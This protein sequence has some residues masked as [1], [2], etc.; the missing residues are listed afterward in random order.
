MSSGY[1]SDIDAIQS[2]AVVPTILDVVCRTTGMRFAAVARVTADRWIACTVKDDIAFGLKPGGELKIDTTICNDIRGSHEPVI[3]NHVAKDERYRSHQTPA[4]Y[5]FQSYISMPILLPDGQ[6]FGTLCAIDPKPAQLTNPATIGMF[7]L[8]AELIGYHLD[9]L[10]RADAIVTDL[11]KA[12]D[13]LASREADLAEERSVAVLREQFVGILAHDL[14][15]PL[16][17]IQSGIH[18]VQR[19]PVNDRAVRVL[20]VMQQSTARMTEL[21]SNMLDFTRTRLGGGMSLGRINN[22]PVVDTIKQVVSELK[23]SWPQHIVQTHFA[24]SEPVNCD[25]ARI[26]QLCSNLLSN[27]LAHGS[28]SLPVRVEAS[29]TGG[30]FTLAVVNG[31]EPIPA[32]EIAHLFEPFSRGRVQSNQQGLGLGLHIA[33]EIA[34]AHGGEISVSS[35]VEETRFTLRMLTKIDP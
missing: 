24:V 30:E 10:Q 20:G 19:T 34:R 1:Q 22:A 15:N 32:A 31:G 7:R 16:S 6:F 23:V 2:I 14:R 27:A 13:Q 29:S 28:K 3:I 8:F 4:M 18:L 33:A 9:A 5:G 21:I 25:P 11:A 12:R 17:A 35:T 26:A